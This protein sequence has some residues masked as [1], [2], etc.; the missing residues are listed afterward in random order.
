MQN[1]FMSFVGILLVT[2]VCALVIALLA[3]DLVGG[4]RDLTRRI[5]RTG[6]EMRRQDEERDAR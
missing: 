5:R 3:W 4:G 2:A 1:V 6:D